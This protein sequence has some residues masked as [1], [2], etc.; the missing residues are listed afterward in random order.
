MC[1]PVLDL[2]KLPVVLYIADVVPLIPVRSHL[3]ECW[4]AA[5]YRTLTRTAD[6]AVYS[7]DVLAIDRL[8]RETKA[9]RTIGN[10]GACH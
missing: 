10:G 4:T 5:T 2:G 9:R 6:G 3:Q 7:S 8:R 1:A